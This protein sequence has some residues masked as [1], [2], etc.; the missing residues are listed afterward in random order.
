[1]Y[2]KNVYLIKQGEVSKRMMFILKG[3]AKAYYTD[4]KGIKHISEFIFENKPVIYM[5]AF[6]KNTPSGVNVVT[7]EDTEVLWASRDH[8]FEFLQKFPRFES[9]LRDMLM[10]YMS[11]D[12]EHTRILRINSSRERYET[13]L[14]YRPDIIQRV[15]LKHI[16]SYLNMALET[17]SRVRAGK[18]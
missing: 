15:P 16:A 10:Q 17:L 13:L 3:V 2:K 8:F 12:L 7:L 5:E 9:V 18:L 11:L 14:K 6:T 4:D 1:M